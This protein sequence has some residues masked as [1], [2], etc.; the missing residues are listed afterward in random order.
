MAYVHVSWR[1][2]DRVGRPHI[3]NSTLYDYFDA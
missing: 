1:K 2:D 3:T